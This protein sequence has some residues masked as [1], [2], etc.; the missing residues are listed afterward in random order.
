MTTLKQAPPP[1]N[2]FPPSLN[3]C[4]ILNII[5]PSSAPLK[6]EYFKGIKILESEII[7]RYERNNKKIKLLVNS[8]NASKEIYSLNEVFTFLSDTDEMRLKN[9]IKAF[10]SADTSVVVCGRGGYGAIRLFRYF[11]QKEVMDQII[12]GLDKHR[13]MGF[14]DATFLHQVFRLEYARKHPGKHLITIHGP[15]PMTSF[16]SIPNRQ[17]DIDLTFNAMVETELNLAFPSVA[18]KVLCCCSE[19]IRGRLVGGSL[20]CL[21][22]CEGTKWSL[23][24]EEDIILFLEDINVSGLSTLLIKNP[25]NFT[26]LTQHYF[27]VSYSTGNAISIR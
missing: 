2:I 15:M 24:R 3:H 18:G 1:S 26:F 10:S 11:E 13:F 17:R 25:Y 27:R 22:A 20:T 19:K 7:K 8:G 23:E 21:L 14:S 4:K 5:F 16:F 12:E 6:V 9:L